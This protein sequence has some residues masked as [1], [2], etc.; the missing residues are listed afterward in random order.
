[1]ELIDGSSFIFPNSNFEFAHFEGQDQPEILNIAFATPTLRVAGRNLREIALALQ[2]LSAD[3]LSGL[4][5]SAL[6]SPSVHL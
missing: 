6:R 3:F 2:M 5:S 4:I 1:V